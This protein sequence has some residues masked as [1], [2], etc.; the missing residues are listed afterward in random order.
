MGSLDG[1]DQTSLF[2]R[3]FVA[4]WRPWP[5][6]YLKGQRPWPQIVT[7]ICF[8]VAETRPNRI[9]EGRFSRRLWLPCRLVDNDNRD[10]RVAAAPAAPRC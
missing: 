7:Y 5:A 2:S 6:S 1:R 4:G 10:R 8:T 9:R 3:G